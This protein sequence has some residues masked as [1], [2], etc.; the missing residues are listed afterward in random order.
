MP[1]ELIRVANLSF[2]RNGLDVLSGI[3]FSVS[4]G[5]YLGIA[6]PNGSGKSTLIKLLLGL[7]P[8]TSGQVSV[9]GE[10]PNSF[11]QWSRVGYLPQNLGP[12]NQCFPATVFEIVRLGLLAGRSASGG[13]DGDERDKVIQ[14]LEFLGVSDLAKRMVWEL[15]GGQQQRVMLARAIVNRPELLFM[16][17]PTAALDPEIR[18]KFYEMVRK[19]NVELGTTVL[20]VTHDIGSV[21]GYASKMLYID[22]TA[23]F[24]G[25]FEQFCHSPEMSAFFGEHAQHIICHRH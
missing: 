5:D 13:A 14:S 8:R 16:D 20:L 6:G 23:R 15:S 2:C 7:L 9:F 4:A 10:D 18:D 22:K 17:E 21:G 19:L 24:F 25:T 11:S 1:E 12:M 3:S